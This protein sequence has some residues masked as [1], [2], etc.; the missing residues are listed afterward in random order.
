[1]YRGLGLA[2]IALVAQLL[3]PLSSA[4]AVAVVSIA[5]FSGDWTP[6]GTSDA[7]LTGHSFALFPLDGITSAQSLVGSDFSATFASY[8]DPSQAGTPI[9]YF[10]L[11][12][13]WSP[14]GKMGGCNSPETQGHVYAWGSN[15][16]A[17]Y[18]H[19]VVLNSGEL[20]LDGDWGLED[21]HDSVHYLPLRAHHAVTTFL[22]KIKDSQIVKKQSHFYREI[23]ITG[24]GETRLLYRPMNDCSD[25]AV[26][27]GDGSLGLEVTKVGGS[28]FVDLYD[29]TLGIEPGRASGDF[30]DCGGEVKELEEIPVKVTKTDRHEKDAC[31]VG[32]EGHL[33]L[34]DHTSKRSDVL[35]LSVPSCQIGL[36]VKASKARKGDHVAVAIDLNRNGY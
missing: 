35:T 20:V 7:S 29:L 10:E 18:V 27:D 28:N 19:Q 16:D 1:M 36:Q 24:S 9:T 21:S 8:C 30:R 31:P 13:T 34:E 3:V 14:G 12:D 2:V 25:T 15:E 22:T 26:D 4:S 11:D 23:E 5:D 6:D 17:A 33:Y 32:A